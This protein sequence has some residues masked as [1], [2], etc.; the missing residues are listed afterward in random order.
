MTGTTIA[1]VNFAKKNEGT[2][3]AA[4][5]YYEAAAGLGLSVKWYQLADSV[6]INDYMAYPTVITGSRLPFKSLRMGY[7]RLIHMPRAAFSIISE[8]HVFISDPTA[9]GVGLRKGHFMLKVHD[10]IRL[11]EYSPGFTSWAMFNYVMKRA[12]H[13]D[14]I[15]V[16]TMHMKRQLEKYLEPAENTF[17]VPE[18]VNDSFDSF[19]SS[20]RYD[21]RDR[22]EINVLYVSA[23]R[24][25]K[26]IKMFLDI[27]RL[28]Q[29]RS[30]M[31][32]RFTLVSKLNSNTMSY[33][34]GLGLKNLEIN[35]DVK[36]L[37]NIYKAADILL[38]PSLVEGFGRPIVEAMAA[39]IPTIARDADPFREIVGDS[40]ILLRSD[41]AED[42]AD[43]IESMFDRDRY[44]GLSRKCRARFEK[45]YSGEVFRKELLKAFSAF[46][47]TSVK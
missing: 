46:L 19:D 4:R 23:D 16:T 29:E 24:P 22:G 33:A 17:I 2:A 9:I 27:A 36:S 35:E 42:W 39:G 47:E 20:Y 12:K 25:Y 10:F 6:D 41:N 3:I 13:A 15:I 7:D 30:L 8:D 38:Y 37:V 18:P 5:I 34:N 44:I 28:F 11:T 43:A 26:N 45:T 40:G 32:Y 14:T 1:F 21:E 31:E